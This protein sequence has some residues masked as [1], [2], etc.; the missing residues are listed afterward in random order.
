MPSDDSSK[1]VENPS[2]RWKGEGSKK[3]RK[4]TTRHKEVCNTLHNVILNII[5]NHLY[6]KFGTSNVFQHLHRMSDTS[7]ATNEILEKIVQHKLGLGGYSILAAQIVSIEKP[8]ML[9][10]NKV[11]TIFCFIAP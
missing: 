1:K 4:D 7:K 11:K 2:G 5:I 9:P 3:I 8:T 6:I 10:N